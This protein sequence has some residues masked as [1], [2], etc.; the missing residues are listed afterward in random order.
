M[1]L[2]S[3]NFS[4]IAKLCSRT[5]FANAQ[6]Y[7]QS[8]R[9]LE[10]NPFGK[11]LRAKV[12]GIRTYNIHISEQ[13]D[14][15]IATS[16]CSCAKNS[17]FCKHSIAVM[18]AWAT[19][20]KRRF[21]THELKE[22]LSGH[23]QDALIA[24]LVSACDHY[25]IL[26]HLLALDQPEAENI[27]HRIFNALQNAL[28]QPNLSQSR[29]I[30]QLSPFCQEAEQFYNLGGHDASRRALYY[31]MK[32]TLDFAKQNP[33]LWEILP[34]SFLAMCGRRYIQIVMSDPESYRYK[35]AIKEELRQIL[36]NQVSQRIPFDFTAILNEPTTAKLSNQEVQETLANH[37]KN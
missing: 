3:L 23:S 7:Y 24:M 28:A 15:L 19:Q 14:Q 8:G 34:V 20:S 16:D 32:T 17:P 31:V 10:V 13:P 36:R 6:D 29:L 4:S 12:S 26:T 25:P 18:I 33:V 35:T 22:K 11:G 9:V 30:A 5:V 27:H 2:N 37:Q 21:T 1:S